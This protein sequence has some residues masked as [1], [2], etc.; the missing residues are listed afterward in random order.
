MS[1]PIEVDS[2]DAAPLDVRV[3]D[4]AAGVLEGEAD[5]ALHEGGRD[6]L[7]GCVGL[8]LV[9][10]VDAVDGRDAREHEERIVAC[11]GGRFT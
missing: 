3:E 2:V 7:Q 11:T 4:A 5:G 8:L 6:L 9:K 10:H 1:G